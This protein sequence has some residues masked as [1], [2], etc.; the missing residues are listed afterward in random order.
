MLVVFDQCSV[1]SFV[2]IWPRKCDLRVIVVSKW[3]NNDMLEPHE[4]DT[5]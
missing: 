2:K 1:D 3:P 4:K 5:K